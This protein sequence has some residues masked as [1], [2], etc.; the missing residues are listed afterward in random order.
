MAFTIIL[1]S[2]ASQA[3]AVTVKDLGVIVAAAGATPLSFTENKEGKMLQESVN[4]RTYLTD[5]AH[6]VGSSTLLL[7]DGSGDVV[8][9]DVLNFLDT[10]ILP[11]AS[12]DYGVVKTDDVGEVTTN[13]VGDG[14]ATL[15]NW[16]LGTD[17]AVNGFEVTGLP[18]SPSGP[19]AAA[20]AAYVDSI[21]LTN[22]TWK[23]LVL[24]ADQLDSVNDGINQAGAFYLDGQPLTTN[25]FILYDGTTTETFT[26]LTTA[27]VPFDVQLGIDTD[28][29]MTNLVTA[30]NTDST[31]WSASDLT[32]L[33]SINDGSGAST[34]G[35][36]IMIYRTDQSAAS[37]DD[38]FYGTLGTQA[39]GQYVNFNGEV[40]YQLE[41]STQ[42][43]TT[44]PAQKEFGFG[45]DTASLT[46]N[47]T[48]LTRNEDNIYTWD[49]DS[50]AWQLTGSGSI[51][52]ATVGDIQSLGSSL[53]AGVVD[54][55]ARGDHVHTHGDRGGDG[56]ASQHDADQV[57]VDGTYPNIGTP[58]DVET[59]LGN[60]NTALGGAKAGRLL[61]FGQTIKVPNSG[62]LFLRSAGGVLGSAAGLRMLR[63]GTIT[64]ASFQVDLI[65]GVQTYNLSIQL[66]GSEVLTLAL[67]TSTLGAQTV[68]LSQA[69]SAG[70]LISVA[71]IRQTG[72]AK[73]TFDDMAAMVEIVDS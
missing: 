26:F 15:N 51:T 43:S 46:A 19:T 44:D 3:T 9:T 20:S 54:R 36:V 17:L 52:W 53:A 28:T 13:I 35:K 55:A 58:S 61:Q 45:R 63:A 6:G 32:A 16:L 31:L 56:S 60:I 30:I 71:V 18:A 4:L 72:T 40:D 29:T 38:R 42:L 2:N 21:A 67:G 65:D 59:A 69:Y 24:S 11:D 33:N 68:A 47:E 27:V 57:D 1:K 25:T 50:G 7:N 8:Q 37:F 34:A 62:T 14:S 23:E 49:D 73:S 10:T 41:T 48:H 12:N 64:G 5:N 39:F 22:R 70:D 66:N